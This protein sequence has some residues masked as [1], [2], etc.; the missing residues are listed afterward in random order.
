MNWKSYFGDID[1]YATLRKHKHIVSCGDTGNALGV[2]RS[3]GEAGIRPIVLCIRENHIP[4]LIKS[5]YVG[6][7]IWVEQKESPVD[8]LLRLYGEEDVHPFIY[9]CDD[10]QESQY[11]LRYAEL[12][13][14]FY[15]F[16]GQN[17]G[18]INFLMNKEEICKVAALCGCSIPKEEVVSTGVMPVTLAYPVITKTLMSI[19]G[20]WKEDSFI[21]KNEAELREAYTKIESPQLLIQEYVHK[22]NEVAIMGFSIDG[23][24]EICAPFQ[25][26]YYRLPEGAYGKYMY[27]TPVK[28]IELLKK[29]QAIIQ[30]CHYSGCFEIEF[31]VDLN[32]KLIFLEVNF[33]YSFWNYSVTYGGINYPLEWAKATLENHI[34]I[35]KLNVR[36]TLFK[37]MAEPSD[38]NNIRCGIVK[39]WTWCY[40]LLTADV[41]YFWNTKD[42]LPTI[43]FWW[44][45]FLRFLRKKL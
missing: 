1:R 20:K 40:Q 37:A 23:G 5:K 21:C 9:I 31:L 32:D 11:D 34:D 41:H 6:K 42:P 28:D 3:L 25:L 10:S 17:A 26:S 24:R 16:H 38:M 15:F 19:M 7:L 12:K 44:N 43:S 35:S 4:M 27:F 13:D 18:A 2:V 45:K 14:K 30:A 29:I 8:V 22:K 39:P 36:C 33:R